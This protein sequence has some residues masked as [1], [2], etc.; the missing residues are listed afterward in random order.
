MQAEVLRQLQEPRSHPWLLL[1]SQPT[2]HRQATAVHHR[3]SNLKE[4]PRRIYMQSASHGTCS[5]PRVQ[6]TEVPLL[7]NSEACLLMLQFRSAALLQE[8]S[9]VCFAD[10]LA[11]GN[12][13]KTV[14]K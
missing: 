8:S 1:S 4:L 5:C 13:E 12:V 9:R 3:H 6:A 11:S 2:T 7:A 10:K 14:R